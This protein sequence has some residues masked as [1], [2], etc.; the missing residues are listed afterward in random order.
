MSTITIHDTMF[1]PASV[2]SGAAVRIETSLPA[3]RRM[4]PAFAIGIVVSTVFW[5]GGPAAL[6]AMASLIG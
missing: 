1:T 4:D 2:E 5:I 3:R 6:W